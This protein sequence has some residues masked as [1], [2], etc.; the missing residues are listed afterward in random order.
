MQLLLTGLDLHQSASILVVVFL[1][2]LELTSLLEQCFRCSAALI[3]EYLFL[4]EVCALS[5]LL[6]LVAV[7]LV[8]HLEVIESVCECLD[9]GLALADL[10]VEFVT[11][12][13]QLLLLLRCLD[14]IVGLRVVSNGLDLARGAL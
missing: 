9:L 5:A 12:A 6:K 2:F 7:V 11:V 4:F 1:K 14:H 13:L 8:S 10:A 3:L